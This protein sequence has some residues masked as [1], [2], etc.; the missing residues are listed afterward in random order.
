MLLHFFITDSTGNTLVVEFLNGKANF[1]YGESLPEKCLTNDT[2]G[3]EINQFKKYG[4]DSPSRFSTVAYMLDNYKSDKNNS[5]IDYSYS[6]LDS[7]KAGDTQSQVV[8]DIGERKIFFRSHIS[9][10]IKTVDFS[11]FDF[12]C[13]S[14]ILMIDMNGLYGGNVNDK[15][16][17]FDTKIN[18]DFTIRAC[19]DSHFGIP[20]EKILEMVKRCEEVICNQK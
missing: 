3:S 8:Y 9:P 13:D 16:I 7:V 12:N 14:P 18:R 6:I 20:M 10:K 17:P 2:Y 5:I 11:H 15:F 19:H 1:Y 4:Y